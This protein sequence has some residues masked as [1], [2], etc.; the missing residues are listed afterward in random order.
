MSRVRLAILLTA[1][2][3]ALGFAGQAAAAGGR[4]VFD[5]GTRG[6]QTQ[7]RKALDASSFDWNVVPATITIHIVRGHNSEAVRGE[8][9]LDANL[10]DAGTFSWGVVQHEFAHQ[11]DFF[12]LDDAKRAALARLGGVTWW[13]PAGT[14][15]S[16]PT[17]SLSHTQLTSERFASTLA[18]AYWPSPKNAMRP[19]SPQDEAGGM[20]P[21]AFRAL[22][23]Q[24]LAS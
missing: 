8:I 14:L 23:A 15:A 20:A 21:A 24:L 1:A 7:V 5:G 19:A 6:E 12:L 13:A 18:W 10:L 22:L 16:A 11:V 17:G 3:A 4:Y 9:W 2:V